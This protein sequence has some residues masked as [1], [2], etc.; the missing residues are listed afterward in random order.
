MKLLWISWL[1]KKEIEK[2]TGLLAEIIN[3]N[4]VAEEE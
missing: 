1:K 3:L 4:E 2:Q